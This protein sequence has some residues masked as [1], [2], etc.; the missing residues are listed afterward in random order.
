[1]ITTPTIFILGA[2]AH[3][4]YGFPNGEQ[5]KKEALQFLYKKDFFAYNSGHLVRAGV[6][7]DASYVS[8]HRLENFIR[9]LTYAGQPSIDA[10]L[11]ANRA[12][13]GFS[14]IG[15]V[16]IA[17][18]LL[19]KEK[20]LPG[21]D[22]DDDWID[23]LFKLMIE[24]AHDPETFLKNR[25]GF[26]TFNYDRTLERWLFVKIQHS[27]GLN[28]EE[29]LKVLKAFPILHV[30]G[31]LGEFMP[32]DTPFRAW[33]AACQRIRTIFEVDETYP[34]LHQAIELLKK[35]E[36]VCFLGFGFHNENIKVLDIPNS[37]SHM[38]MIV[39][40]RFGVTNMEWHRLS[41]PFTGQKI[42][43]SS[44]HQRCKETLRNSQLF[45]WQ[46]SPLS[47]D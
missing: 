32:Y 24:G 45:L 7:A 3:C 26:V 1:M 14:A 12:Q 36:R 18:V 17:Q 30:Y 31:D 35:A 38:K 47:P 19:E 13:P 44:Q 37:M 29:S 6:I 10:F 39:A 33:L 43:G 5:L 46:T 9:A 15:K 34:P 42:H 8:D 40:S 16:A 20:S 11:H 25:V 41:A 23:Y 27:F 4:S 22:G 21:A 2:G 28:E